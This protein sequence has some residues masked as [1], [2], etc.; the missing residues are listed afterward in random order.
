[1]MTVTKKTISG[2]GE[3]YMFMYILF[4]F[5][6]LYYTFV[7]FLHLDILPLICNIEVI[8]GIII[9]A[10]IPLLGAGILADF[11]NA[12][13]MVF[14]RKKE[15]NVSKMKRAIDAIN[16]EIRAQLLAASLTA[17]GVLIKLLHQI[18]L[19]DISQME[20]SLGGYLDFV[21]APLF[22]A[23]LIASLLLPLKYRIK[24]MLADFM[25]RPDE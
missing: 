15:Q 22:Y 13:K 1:M 2:Q 21:V 8:A 18:T 11:G 23:L 9:Y 20:F 17:V 5:V 16:L 19:P 4:V 25:S 6:F 3:L 24:G 14:S 12:F 10:I 7:H